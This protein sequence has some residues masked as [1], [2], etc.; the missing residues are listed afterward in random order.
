M[1]PEKEGQK[2]KKRPKTK[3]TYN[4]ES[5]GKKT[6]LN[7]LE[8]LASICDLIEVWIEDR[9]KWSMVTIEDSPE[10]T[11]DGASPQWNSESEMWGTAIY[12]SSDC[13]D[14]ATVHLAIVDEHQVVT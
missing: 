9:L 8:W 10:L 13:L 1:S 7:S 3:L 5:Q 6:W 4:E 2:G 12:R 11:K 14:L